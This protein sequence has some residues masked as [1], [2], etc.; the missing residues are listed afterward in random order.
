MRLLAAG[1]L[2]LLSPGNLPAQSDDIDRLVQQLSS[3]K[4]AERIAAMKA[5]EEKGAAALPALG[6]AVENG[7]LE[8]QHRAAL[9]IERIEI[10]LAVAPVL[11]GTK[12][13]LVYKDEPVLRAVEDLWEKFGFKVDVDGDRVPL[14]NR[15]ITLDTGEV[16]FWEALT[17]FCLA[18]G[19]TERPAPANQ[20]PGPRIVA[21]RLALIAGKIDLTGTTLAGPVRLKVL[22]PGNHKA[23]F[24]LE[25]SAEPRM[26]WQ[27]VRGLR[28][29]KI[30]DQKGLL[31]PLPDPYKTPPFDRSPEERLLY[32]GNVFAPEL[33]PVLLPAAIKPGTKLKEIHGTLTADVQV[34]RKFAVIKNA[35]VVKGKTFRVGNVDD[36]LKVL[37]IQ[38]ET[39]RLHMQL[40]IDGPLAA[41]LAQER[42]PKIGGPRNLRSISFALLDTKGKPW[43]LSDQG[44]RVGSEDDGNIFALVDVTFQRNAKQDEPALLVVNG[45]VTVQVEIPFVLRNVLLP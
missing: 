7:E 8:L 34:L 19:L 26:P 4:Y 40:R 42:F 45:A 20:P 36:A 33:L 12:I 14:H 9:V 25:V 11:A 18:A 37:N 31:L 43:Q 16:T 35:A 3:S 21:V 30:V 27:G 10:R 5:L 22:Q 38:R 39:D 17:Q 41:S 32:T 23:A 1:L 6:K 15:K 24:L 44:P 29:S 28:I 13:R 2:L